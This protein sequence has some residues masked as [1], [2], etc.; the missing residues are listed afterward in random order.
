MCVCVE[1]RVYTY[2]FARYA[3]DCY[4]LSRAGEFNRAVRQSDC[5][6]GGRS[7]EAVFGVFSGA[8]W[9][10]IST[11]SHESQDLWRHC[12]SSCSSASTCSLQLICMT[13]SAWPCISLI[14]RHCRAGESVLRARLFV[15]SWQW[16]HASAGLAFGPIR[17]RQLDDVKQ[18]W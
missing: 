12:V 11:R 8:N 9:S 4:S 18:Y 6:I 2:V 16:R 13:V 17:S 3:L 15:I 10:S 5:R 7:R 14:N 1:R